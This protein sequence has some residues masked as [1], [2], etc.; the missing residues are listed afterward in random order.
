MAAHNFD[1]QWRKASDVNYKLSFHKKFE[2]LMNKYY[3]INYMNKY[4]GS[5]VNLAMLKP[6]CDLPVFNE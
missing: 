6:F 5:R 2:I 4:N 3:G 1:C